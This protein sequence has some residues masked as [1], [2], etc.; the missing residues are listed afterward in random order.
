MKVTPG[1]CED[2]SKKKQRTDKNSLYENNY[3]MCFEYCKIR[4]LYKT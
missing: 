1:E 2:Q 4:Y 3:D